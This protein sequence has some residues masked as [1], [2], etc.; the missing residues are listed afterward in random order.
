MYDG[1]LL[2]NKPK[3]WTSHDV[4]AKV[5]NTLKKQAGQKIKVGHSGTLDPMATG[6]LVLLA[7]SYCK[8]AQEFSKLDKTYEAKIKLGET[9]STGDAEGD[10]TKISNKKPAGNEVNSALNYFVG[11]IQQTPPSYSAVKIEGKRAY[12][13]AREGK[14]V[15]IK[16][17]TITIYGINQ[18][19]YEYPYISFVVSAS[20]GTYIRSL[21]E[22]IGNRL[23]T[24]AYL[25]E[26]KRIKVGEFKLDK[27]LNPTD[28]NIDKI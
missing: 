22:D 16:P 14:K 1:V 4:V 25:R 28:V 15:E 24:G 5:R 12:K 17:R 13:L 19:S 7:G 9:S 18:V 20:S 11:E 23:D 3:G 27:S 26:L 10:K 6:L 21:A 2:I 8:K